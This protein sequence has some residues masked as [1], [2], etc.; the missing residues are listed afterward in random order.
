MFFKIKNNNSNKNSD[1][2]EKPF[3]SKFYILAVSALFILMIISCNKLDPNTPVGSSN[4][5]EMVIDSVDSISFTQAHVYSRVLD[6]KNL[7]ITRYGFCWDTS[8][9]PTINDR[10][11]DYG[12]LTGSKNFDA[13]VTN[14]FPE[15]LNYL[16]MYFVSGKIVGYCTPIA[17][18][19]FGIPIPPDIIK[20]GT[21]GNIGQ[22]S[23]EVNGTILNDG[24]AI[25]FANYGHCWSSSTDK[26]TI[27]NDKTAL[28]NVLTQGTF[29]YTSSLTNLSSAMKYYVRAYAILLNSDTIYGNTIN[30]RTN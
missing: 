10:F 16:R 22:N 28:G 15:K 29:N 4:K 25:S 23:A 14:L 18:R 17:F 19:T 8:E 7:Q 2:M 9:F 20:T 12:V 11:N 6:I 24:I 26:P 1:T 21:V 13:I 5:V 30:F 27:Q 3:F